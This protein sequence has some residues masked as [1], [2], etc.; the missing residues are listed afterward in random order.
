MRAGNSRSAGAAI[1]TS[2][3]SRGRNSVTPA[4][5]MVVTRGSYRHQPHGHGGVARE[6]RGRGGHAE[7]PG[8]ELGE[9]VAVVGG[10][11]EVAPLEAR[12]RREPRPAAEDATAA[13]RPAD[14]E[15]R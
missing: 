13:Q 4:S 5:A 12:L 9:H 11:G 8:E 14:G 2:T 15:E 6:D 1:V 7:V 3:P 10:D